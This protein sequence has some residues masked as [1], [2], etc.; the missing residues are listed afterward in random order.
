[1]RLNDSVGVDTDILENDM[2]DIETRALVVELVVAAGI[3][4]E[5][6]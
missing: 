6:R 4:L 5:A 2:E 3:R 1:M